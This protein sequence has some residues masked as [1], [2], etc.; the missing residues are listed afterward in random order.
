M[1][2]KYHNHTLQPN[3]RH[4]KEEP[5]NTNSQKTPGRQLK[6]NNQLSLPRQDDCK[7]RKDMKLC[8][9]IEEQRYERYQMGF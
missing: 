3:P 7:T 5:Q 8:M 2:R 1:V 9:Q 6:Q 4:R